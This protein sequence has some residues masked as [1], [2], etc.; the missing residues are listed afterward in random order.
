MLGVAMKMKRRVRVTTPVEVRVS[1]EEVLPA[2]TENVSL[3][4]VF[5]KSRVT[6]PEGTHV[7][8]RLHTPHG[9]ITTGARVV[10]AVDSR[11]AMATSRAPGMGLS[12]ASLSPYAQSVLERLLDEHDATPRDPWGRPARILRSALQWFV[13]G[14]ATADVE[15]TDEEPWYHR[16]AAA[17]GP[18]P[19]DKPPEP[20]PAAKPGSSGRSSDF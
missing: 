17:Q 19:P 14:A 7:L 15:T 10:H 4:G 11:E 20:P 6:L 8:L 16:A 5:V 9:R 2:E 13:S 18:H 3:G 12:M 1:R